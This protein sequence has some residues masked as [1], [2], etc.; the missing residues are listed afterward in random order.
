MK[1]RLNDFPGQEQFAGVGGETRGDCHKA[2]DAR[3]SLESPDSPI[4]ALGDFNCVE[5]R[6]FSTKGQSDIAGG[7]Q[8]CSGS[9][10]VEAESFCAFGD[11]EAQAPRA[12]EASRFI[13]TRDDGH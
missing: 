7:V 5:A 9:I 8:Q 4:S 10:C 13:E 12:R 11:V 1:I 2:F 6:F 3:A